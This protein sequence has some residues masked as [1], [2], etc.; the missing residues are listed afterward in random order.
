MS[1]SDQVEE[2]LLRWESAR[3]D[4]EALSP[5]ALCAE[6]PHL[7]PELR[8]RIH[9]IESMEQVLGVTRGPVLFAA[10]ASLPRIP[11]YRIVR[12]LDEGGMGVVYEAVQVSLG[13]TV[14]VKMISGVRLGAT[15]LARFRAE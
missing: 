8:C 13:R 4:G 15:Q 2:L 11:G 14:A 6:F 3:R 9:L 12:V 5:E 7:T 10:P 1:T